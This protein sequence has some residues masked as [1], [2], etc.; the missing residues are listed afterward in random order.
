M[1]KIDEPLRRLLTEPIDRSN[2]IPVYLQIADS[3]RALLR[4]RTF[5][6]GTLLPPER[7]LC[8]AFHVSRMTL[9]QAFD[10]LEREHLIQSQ[11]GR[12]TLVCYPRLRKQQQEMRSF[13]E[14]I[15]AR[16]GNPQSRLMRFE[17][18]QPSASLQNLLQLPPGQRVFRI[19][20]LRMDSSVPLAVERVEVPCY[21]C[22]TLQ[23]FDLARQSLYQILENEFGLHLDR[24]TE[25][26]S[27]VKATREQ[28]HLLAL[29]Q[30]VGILRIERRAFT[31]N[32]TPIEV[33]L[34]AYRADMYQ[35]IVHST[36]VKPL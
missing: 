19:E 16:G 23:Q 14:E 24:S 12:G 18:V 35:A 6:P 9:R 21:L 7:L 32:N 10:I 13:T 28:R 31:M 34:T 30:G 11:R 27:A 20:R 26:I 25:T 1:T 36:R 33:S 15:R 3:L 5:P 8:E 29:P 22:P 4:T 2:P 17:E